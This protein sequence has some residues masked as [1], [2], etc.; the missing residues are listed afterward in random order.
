MALRRAP[1]S[2]EAMRVHIPL[3]RAAP[4]AAASPAARGAEKPRRCGG[5]GLTRGRTRGLTRVFLSK[6][7]AQRRYPSCGSAGDHTIAPNLGGREIEVSK[8]VDHSFSDIAEIPCSVVHYPGVTLDRG[9]IRTDSAW[10]R[11]GDVSAGLGCRA[12]AI[13]ERWVDRTPIGT[14]VSLSR[15]SLNTL[16]SRASFLFCPYWR[17]EL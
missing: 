1:L 5:E 11:P 2:V 4:L 3:V 12:P 9:T 8:Q 16:V 13:N 10:H 15:A 14:S 6:E 17:L 7:R